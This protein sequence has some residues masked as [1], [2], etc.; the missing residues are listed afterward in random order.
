MLVEQS[1]RRV[2]RKRPT[3]TNT[4]GRY[5]G[6]HCTT[7]GSF[8][9][10]RY[11]PATIKTVVDVLQT[12]NI[13]RCAFLSTPSIF[14]SLTDKNL[15]NG[16]VLF[17]L[18][19]A[20]RNDTRWVRYDY[21]DP[22]ALPNTAVGAFDAV[23]IDPPFITKGVWER[24]ASTAKRLLRDGAATR[25][26]LTTT[27]ENGDLVGSLLG[28]HRVPF[29]PCIPHLVYQYDMYANWDHHLL[30]QPNDELL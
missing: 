20:F 3:S 19:D 30:N 22:L 17:D 28:V 6:R 15:A 4:G 24:Y 16:S 27:A 2:S 26:L 13:D 23:V 25:I 11:S 18:D 14:Y 9:P 7:G 21:K 5:P 29:Q 8:F 12:S 1:S 10:N